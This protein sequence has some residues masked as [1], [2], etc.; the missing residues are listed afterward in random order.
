MGDPGFL[1][2]NGLT[3]VVLAV[4]CI[5]GFWIVDP[6]LSCAFLNEQL[7]KTGTSALVIALFATPLIGIVVQSLVFN[8]YYFLGIYPTDN[9]ARKEFR[10][11]LLTLEHPQGI[12]NLADTPA[13]SLFVIPYYSA[14]CPELVKWSRRRLDWRRLYDNWML[15]AEL[16]LSIGISSIWIHNYHS[17]HYW[18]YLITV[19]GS[20]FLSCL[21]FW[22]AIRSDSW[23]NAVISFSLFLLL[24]CLMAYLIIPSSITR[25]SFLPVFLLIF[26]SIGYH[27]MR[28][29]KDADLMEMLWV[30]SRVNSTNDW[31]SLMYKKQEELLF[32]D[33]LIDT[34]ESQAEDS[35]TLANH[36]GSHISIF[37]ELFGRWFGRT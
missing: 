27:Q 11:K 7:G 8:V 4:F 10:E 3:G 12:D 2:Q 21:S 20:A 31:R 30:Q 36:T 29:K 1:L 23:W 5:Y 33:D 37:L 14:G 35:P 18:F 26:I 6:G 34:K 24:T 15:A 19:V 16:G 25:I 28:A 32:M 9:D 17:P 22:F 13:D